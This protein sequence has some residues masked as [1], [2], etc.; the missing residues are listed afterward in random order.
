MREWERQERRTAKRYNG[1]RSP[2][3]GAGHSRKNDVRNEHLLIENKT[4]GNRT[5]ITLHTK[6][7]EL[8]RCNA[9]VE[10]RVPV[11]QFDLAGRNYVVLHEGDF[12]DRLGG[13]Q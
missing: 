2:R 11:L 3:S 9:S 8:L 12:Y 1:Q 4:T 6:D 10:G 7:L 5:Q 13:D